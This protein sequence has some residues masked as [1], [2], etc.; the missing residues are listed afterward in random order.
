MAWNTHWQCCF[1]SLN[2]TQY[3]VNICEQDYDGDIVQLTGAAEPFT[4]QED[5]SEDIFTPIRSQSGYLRVIDPDGTLLADIIPQ[6]N[7]ERLVQL[8]HGTYTGVWPDGTFTHAADALEWQGFLQAQAYTQPWDGNANELELPVK[9]LLGALED[10]TIAEEYAPVEKNVAALILAAFSQFGLRNTVDLRY[11]HVISDATDPVNTLLLPILQWSVFFS[12]ETINNEGDSYNQLV[13][14]SYSE[15]LSAVMSLYGWQ[16]RENGSDIY[17]V[18]YD[19][20]QPYHDGLRMQTISFPNLQSMAEGNRITREQKDVPSADMLTALTFRGADNVAGYVQGGRSAKVELDL[21]KGARFGI[22]LPQT[23][24]DSTQPRTI[25]IEDETYQSGT[26]YVQVHEPRTNSRETFNFKRYAAHEASVEDI[27][28][29]STFEDCVD[30]SVLEIQDMLFFTN[31]VH[32]ERAITTGCFPCRW[33]PKLSS[34][35]ESPS[36]RNG[37]FFNVRPGASS[38]A[39]EQYIKTSEAY[40]IKSLFA[41]DYN[42]GYIN[43]SFDV[44]MFY[45]LEGWARLQFSDFYKFNGYD[46]EIVCVA[47]LGSKYW[48]GSSWV[49]S[50]AT[51]TIEF[52][53]SGMVSNKTDAMNVEGTT[54]YFIPLDGTG[55]ETFTLSVVNTSKLNGGSFDAHSFIL[56][57]LNVDYRYPRNIV[58]SERSQNVY[59]QSITASG[60]SEDK[61]IALSVGTINNNVRYPVFI[62]SD[63]SSYIEQLTYRTRYSTT[64]QQR[65]EL[66]LLDRMVVQFGQVRRLFTAI[67]QR[68]LSLMDTRYTYQERAYFGVKRQTNWRDDTEEVKFIEVS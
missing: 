10:V 7:T 51:F 61:Q 54:G 11:I 17:L 5:E 49:S 21:G 59:W 45:F 15:A 8:Y 64:K 3:A 67:A 14:V 22:D 39:Q 19:A 6:N 28:T 4:T 16:M 53:A 38:T 52:N 9:S 25:E 62:K 65:P 12:E 32:L 42:G 46:P 37:M 2:G 40:A 47:K 43:I 31:P 50:Y 56:D 60:F 57:N 66:H 18:Q 30:T 27:V 13:G 41:L 29:A 23:T 26:V 68:G 36:L 58:E 35:L 24:E 34:S 63:S 33:A 20:I 55:V 44:H 1:Q 48:N